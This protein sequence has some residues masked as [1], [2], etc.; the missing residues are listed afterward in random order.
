MFEEYKKYSLLRKQDDMSTNN[1]VGSE[2][3]L[4]STNWLGRYSNFIMFESFKRDNTEEQVQKLMQDDH[5]EAKHPG[6]IM[7]GDE[8]CEEDKEG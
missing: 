2:A 4:I 8:L 1:P 6:A 5:F 3:Y 7:N